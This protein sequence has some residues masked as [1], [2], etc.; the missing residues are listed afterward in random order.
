MQICLF[1]WLFGSNSQSVSSMI[2]LLNILTTTA[3][4]CYEPRRPPCLVIPTELPTEIGQTRSYE[5]Q[6]CLHS[7]TEVQD[8]FFFHVILIIEWIYRNVFCHS[9]DI[10][11]DA[12]AYVFHHFTLYSS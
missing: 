11:I 12:G 6:V 10:K 3:E 2:N 4:R 8:G 1:L 5:D 9:K 7:P